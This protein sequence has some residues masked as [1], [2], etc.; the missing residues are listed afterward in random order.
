MKTPVPRRASRCAILRTTPNPAFW[1]RRDI[2]EV[3]PLLADVL[4]EGRLVYDLPTIEQMRELRVADVSRLDPGVTRM[5][6]PHVYHVSLTPR[7]WDLKQELISS[8][9]DKS[10]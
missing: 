4:R 9:M 3:E 5:V 2:S 8:A 1:A 10:H 6:N 7:L